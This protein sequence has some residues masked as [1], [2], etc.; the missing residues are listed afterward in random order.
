MSMPPPEQSSKPN[1]MSTWTLKCASEPSWSLKWRPEC[2]SRTLLSFQR[3]TNLL[4]WWRSETRC[5]KTHTSASIALISPTCHWSI[6]AVARSTTA[7]GTTCTAGATCRMC[8]SYIASLLRSY[9]LWRSK[10]QLLSTKTVNK[11]AKATLESRVSSPSDGRLV[12]KPCFA[13]TLRPLS[14]WILF[15]LWVAYVFLI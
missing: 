15:W 13:S 5:W 1:T 2:Q 3:G 11:R 9:R 4:R 8:R 10:Q 7:S 6:A 12:N 14:C